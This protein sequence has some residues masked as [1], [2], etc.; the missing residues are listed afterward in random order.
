[1]YL[2]DIHMPTIFLP[3]LSL[4]LLLGCAGTRTALYLRH[5]KRGRR[6]EL[7]MLTLCWG[8]LVVGLL[9]LLLALSGSRS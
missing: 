1:M 2:A 6:E 8:P 3:L 7:F 9:A 4:A 5:T